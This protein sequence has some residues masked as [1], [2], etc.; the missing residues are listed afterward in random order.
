V[1]YFFE[2]SPRPR[3]THDQLCDSGDLQNHHPAQLY[4]YS[5]TGNADLNFLMEA[6]MRMLI[7][8]LMTTLLICVLA[9]PGIAAD[10]PA[11]PAKPAAATAALEKAELIDINSATEA[12]L[13]TLPGIGDAYAKKIIEGRP[14]AKKDQLKAKNI[15]PTATYDKIQ[16]LIIA[17]QK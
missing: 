17:R 12:Q 10:K 6:T 3:Y 1:G 2:K 11:A 7:K 5:Q 13:K 15:I 9:V 8:L 14:Y 16:D 4:R